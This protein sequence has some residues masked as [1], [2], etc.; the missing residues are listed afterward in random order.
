MEFYSDGYFSDGIGLFLH[1]L[2]RP[3]RLLETR[4]S[5]CH[6][7]DGSVVPDCRASSGSSSSN[8][9][10]VGVPPRAQA[11]SLTA[12]LITSGAGGML[13]FHLLKIVDRLIQRRY[14]SERP[15]L[16][17]HRLPLLPQ[18]LPSP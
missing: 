2:R 3:L 17:Q 18:A 6:L 9:A 12:A 14:D 7:A 4:T 1:P 16:M 8:A 13:L 11:V 5:E 10:L 15:L